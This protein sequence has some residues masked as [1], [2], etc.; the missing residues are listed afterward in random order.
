MNDKLFMK[1]Y[2]NITGSHKLE[3]PFGSVVMITFDGRVESE[4][5]NGEILPGGVDTQKVDINKIIHMSARYMAVG[6]D[7]QGNE[8]QLFIEN[9]AFI[10]EGTTMP[11]LTIPTFVTD[12]KMLA[13][14]LHQRIF[15]GEGV[16]EDGHLVI[17]IYEVVK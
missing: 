2:V 11:F 5:F 15:K 17:N 3:S 4:L 16:M 6:K 8:C 10:P 12:S 7:Q 9:N 14:Y 13:D 1:V